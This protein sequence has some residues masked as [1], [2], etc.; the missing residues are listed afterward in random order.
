MDV[1]DRIERVRAALREGHSLDASRLMEE[2]RRW[3][4]SDADRLVLD[5]HDAAFRLAVAVQGFGP[6]PTEHAWAS[7][8]GDVGAVLP[9]LLRRRLALELRITDGIGGLDTPALDVAVREALEL[10]QEDAHA[11]P[12]AVR[13]ASNRLSVQMLVLERVGIAP[14]EPGHADALLAIGDARTL[15]DTLGARGTIDRRAVTAA[16]AMGDWPRAWEWAQHALQED[17]LAPTERAGL[18]YE[19]AMLALERGMPA[20]ARAL[21][22]LVHTS[23]AGRSSVWARLW[24]ASGAV[25]A[26]AAGGGS[27][28]ASLRAVAR[29]VDR[30]KH[31][32]Q[33][34]YAMRAALVALEAGAPAPEVLGFLERCFGERAAWAEP[35]ASLVEG[36]AAPLPWQRL[37]ELDVWCDGPAPPWQRAAALRLR[38]QARIRE[39]SATAAAADIARGLRLLSMWEGHRRVALERL[40][41]RLLPERSITPAQAGVLRLVVEGWTDREIAAELGRSPRT[42]ESHVQALLRAYDARNRV[43]LAV[44]AARE[45]FLE[46]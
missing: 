41:A 42:V 16:V 32:A 4:A 8:R 10:V 15:A 34:H 27:M 19:A 28:T 17:A 21:G 44:A 38:A 13:A 1:H 37:R 11:S 20:E 3:A 18:V 40:R 12:T 39:G 2:A 5:V 35:W 14:G 24:A 22:A 31:R 25:I 7:L 45:P 9:P 6:V 29:S 23:V 26:A 33:P 36:T 43:A 46:A 30:E